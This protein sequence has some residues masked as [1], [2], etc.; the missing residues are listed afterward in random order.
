MELHAT[1]LFAVNLNGAGVALNY[2]VHNGHAKTK[3]LSLTLS[4]EK[5]GEHLILLSLW[6]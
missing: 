5:R 2:L 1:A 6:D 4:C 3:P